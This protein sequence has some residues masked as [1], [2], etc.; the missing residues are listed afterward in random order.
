VRVTLFSKPECHLCE[1]AL[2]ELEHLARTT[3]L[4]IDVVN[5]TTDPVLLKKYGERIPVLQV[6][7]REYAAPLTHEL[8]ERA[9]RGA[10]S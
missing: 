7:G 4:D 6:G 2:L 10:T 8:I 3:P 5:I 9:L 1:E